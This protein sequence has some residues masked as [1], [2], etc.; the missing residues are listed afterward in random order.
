M[1]LRTIVL[2]IFLLLASETFADE[3]KLTRITGIYS[4]LVQSEE[5]GDLS[6]MELIIIP[7]KSSVKV[8]YTVFIQ[9]AEGGAPRTA[10]VPLTV[11]NST[12]QFDFPEMGSMPK[13]HFVG[14]FKGNR[15]IVRWA[16]GSEE[17]LKRG[18]SYWQ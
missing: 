9:I 4:D 13:E 10:I 3:Q 6:G 11:N 12:I 1:G 18:K 2:T 8:P 15:L 17:Q 7:S 16:S 14:V 5:S